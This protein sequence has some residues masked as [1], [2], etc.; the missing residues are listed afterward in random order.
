MSLLTPPQSRTNGPSGQDIDEFRL[1]WEY[2]K[3]EQPPVGPAPASPGGVC[4]DWG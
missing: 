4:M 3:Y 2:A 1:I